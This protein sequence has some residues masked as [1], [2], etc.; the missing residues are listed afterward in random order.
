[1][2]YRKSIWLRI[3]AKDYLQAVFTRPKA[4]RRALW[5]LRVRSKREYITDDPNNP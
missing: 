5:M 2:D 4:L 1:M 3:G